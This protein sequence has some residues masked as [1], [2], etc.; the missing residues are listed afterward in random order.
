MLIMVVLL[1]LMPGDIIALSISKLA[2]LCGA[3][4]SS[5]PVWVAGLIAFTLPYNVLILWSGFYFIDPAVIRSARDLGF[6]NR[7]VFLKVI[8]PLSTV[9]L[10]S[11]AMLTFLLS[12][13]EYSRTYYLSGSMEGLSE[14]LNGRLSSGTDESI[15]AGAVLTVLI[16]LVIVMILYVIYLSKERSKNFMRI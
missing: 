16:T 15:Y 14:Y 1:G 6:S 12:L 13:N 3:Y 11:C 9:P 7:S 4:G 2:N 10:S 8:L 5:L